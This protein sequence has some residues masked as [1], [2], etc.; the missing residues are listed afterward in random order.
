MFIKQLKFFKPLTLG[1]SVAIAFS[2][3]ASANSD[4]TLKSKT[5]LSKIYFGSCSKQYKP[6]PI[7]DAIVADNPELFIFL[8]DNIYGDTEDMSELKDKYNVLGQHPGFKKLKASSELIAIWDDHDYGE[9]D[10]GKEYPE[11][12]ASRQIML[13]FWQ[14]PKDSPRYTRNGIY[15]SYMY[16]EGEQSVHIIMPDLRWNRDKLH[17]V[18]KFKYLT[19]RIPNNM[20]PYQASP[21]AAASMLGEEQWQWFEAELKKPAKIKIIASSL[22]LLP[23]FTG[24]ESWANFPN[25]RNR[26][27]NFIK[28]EKITGV[29]MISGDTHWGEISK[30][31]TN[32]MYPLWEVT[33]SGLSEKWKD[34]SPNKHRQGQFTNQVNYGFIEIDW[35][36]EDPLINFGLKQVDG[37]IFSQQQVKLSSLQ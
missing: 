32:E 20:G 3:P 23:E 29:L 14:E 27:L 11:K 26:L 21:D 24:W 1:L 16:G 19:S 6:M 36:L 5:P 37:K 2:V 15:T 10:A 31:D 13:D 4:E 22:Q 34:V 7:F 33:A 12:E 8:G 25:D 18:S 30:V 28:D 17:E 9:N 35:Q